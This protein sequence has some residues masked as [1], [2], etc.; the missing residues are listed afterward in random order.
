MGA[1]EH[2]GVRRGSWARDPRRRVRRRGARVGAGRLE[3]RPRALSSR[4]RA[5]R[6]VVG[7]ADGEDDDTGRGG[8]G[9]QG[10]GREDRRRHARR[11]ARQTGRRD[12]EDARRP[13]DRGREVRH[14]GFVDDLCEEPADGP[15]RAR[16]VERERG[17]LRVLR[18]A[19]GNRGGIHGADQGSL[20]RSLRRVPEDLPGGLRRR[21]ERRA[22][23]ELQR[24]G[25][26]EH[27]VVG[28]VAVETEERE[29]LR[30]L[31]HEGAAGER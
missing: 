13:S 9:R 14:R 3:G 19:E 4:H 29:G 27:A 31:L 7:R 23:E 11:P 22:G 26:V 24:R 8:A 2:R 18:R 25:G 16:R 30:L 28:A 20:R 10:R 5:E 12:H 1:G 15:R 17:R 21:V 6:V